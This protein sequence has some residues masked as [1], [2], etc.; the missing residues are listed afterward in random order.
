LGIESFL[1][2]SVDALL[3]V[4]CYNQAIQTELKVQIQAEGVELNVKSISECGI[5]KM[6]FFADNVYT[7]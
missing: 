5:G 6:T 3:G 2:M 4:V 7:V 1:I